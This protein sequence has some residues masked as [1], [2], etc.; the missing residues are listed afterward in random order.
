MRIILSQRPLRCI[1][2]ALRTYAHLHTLGNMAAAIARRP[3]RRTHRHVRRC[4][5][6]WKTKCS[7]WALSMCMGLCTACRLCTA[8]S[9]L[10]RE[11]G[12][13]SQCISR[14]R[15]CWPNNCCILG[16]VWCGLCARRRSRCTNRNQMDILTSY[17][18]W[19]IKIDDELA[20]AVIPHGTAFRLARNSFCYNAD[21]NIKWCR[22]WWRCWTTCLVVPVRIVVFNMRRTIG[23]GILHLDRGFWALM[24]VVATVLQIG[25]FICCVYHRSP[26]SHGLNIATAVLALD[27]W[28][29]RPAYSHF[30]IVDRITSAFFDNIK[31]FVMTAHIPDPSE[32]RLFPNSTKVAWTKQF[33]LISWRKRRKRQRR[34]RDQHSYSSNFHFARGLFSM[35][36]ENRHAA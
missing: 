20:L 9:K 35:L 15:H 8:N 11:P 4:Y 26:R 34:K 23:A 33:V 12:R 21:D 24:L 13:S 19:N 22:W 3:S 5:T 28:W 29:L 36:K 10:A 25:K 32:R 1:G 6:R 27:E 7:L 31:R 30:V 18:C 14:G 17:I 16:Y 2:W